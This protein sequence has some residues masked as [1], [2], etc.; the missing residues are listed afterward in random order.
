MNSY[1]SDSDNET[2]YSYENQE[3]DYEYEEEQEPEIYYDNEEEYYDDTPEIVDIKTQRSEVVKSLH[4]TSTITSI[5]KVNPWTKLNDDDNNNSVE[6]KSF[7]DIIKEE[8]I[9]KKKRD[10]M[11]RKRKQVEVQRSHRRNGN[12]NKRYSNDRRPYQKNTSSNNDRPVQSLLL[13]HK[14]NT[15]KKGLKE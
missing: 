11:E 10:E 15:Q 4:S 8:E 5:P 14:L 7:L 2:Y 1:Q 12:G 13:S 9:L 6:T 3:S